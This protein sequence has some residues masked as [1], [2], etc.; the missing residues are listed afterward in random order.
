MKS[1][2]RSLIFK[3]M[4]Y[5]HEEGIVKIGQDQSN[6]Y[7]VRSPLT[8]SRIGHKRSLADPTVKKTIAYELCNGP[9]DR[10]Q[11]DTIAPRQFDIR[12]NLITGVKLVPPD[13]SLNVLNNLLIERNRACMINGQSNTPKIRTI[14]YIEY[15]IFKSKCQAKRM[16]QVVKCEHAYLSG[17]EIRIKNI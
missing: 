16:S 7:I 14:R 9:L 10:D 1:Q 6:G 12:G 11:A 3:V 5:L 13:L 15:T 2:I 17:M 4:G 8:V